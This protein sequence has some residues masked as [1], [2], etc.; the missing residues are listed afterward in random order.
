M[1]GTGIGPVADRYLLDTSA[2]FCLIKDEPGAGTVARLLRDSRRGRATV[3]LAQISLAELYYVTWQAYSENRAREVVTLV[4][5]LPAEIVPPT[6]RIT[7]NA[8]RLKALHRLSLA[9]ALIA[10]TA[11][12]RDAILVH[13]DPEYTA[14]PAEYR[15]LALPYKH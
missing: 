1:S 2:L 10:A 7:L 9:D 12:D 6:E 15:T 3:F 14:L 13:K 5:G 4:K 11:R 8:G